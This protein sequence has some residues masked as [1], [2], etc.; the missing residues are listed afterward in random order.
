MV[1]GMQEAGDKIGREMPYALPDW[2]G[3]GGERGGDNNDMDGNVGE[4]DSGDKH[5]PAN[6]INITIVSTPLTRG[7]ERC[8]R[9][10]AQ[11]AAN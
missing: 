10:H 3:E 6:V 9:W 11:T 5:P 1:H 7:V 4:H 2:A 8:R